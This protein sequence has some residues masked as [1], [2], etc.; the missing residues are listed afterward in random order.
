MKRLL[1]TIVALAVAVVA[2]AQTPIKPIPIGVHVSEDTTI[3]PDYARSLLYDRL[4]QIVTANGLGT[5]NNSPFF[6]T[7]S[8]NLT[9]KDII[10]GAPM[11][12]V[13]NVDISFYVADV[14][15]HRL[16]ETCTL[17]ARGVGENENRAFIA[18]FRNIKSSSPELKR[19]IATAS[20]E[21]VAYY[22][23]Q[24]DNYIKQ[25]DALAKMG[26]FEK[27]LYLLSMVPDACE[28]YGRVNDAAIAVYQKMIDGNSLKMLQKAK[29]VWAAGHDYAAAEEAGLYLAEV[30]PYSS[31]FA[32]AEALVAEIKEFV[33]SER[34]Y[35]R[36]QAEEEIA[37]L[38]KIA[39]NEQD[40]ERNRVNA[41]R[42]V[43][44][45]YG[46]NQP[47]QTYD[48]WWWGK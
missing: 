2:T 5:D 27:A 15:T 26:E 41:W 1:F 18:A 42:E 34:Q 10:A 39:E 44:V 9:D 8:I 45:A 11:R 23:S 38:R 4:N 35:D 47:K 33:I 17:S 20:T 21:I 30:S 19:L 14:Q 37:W 43:G 6:L 12:I 16:Y 36:K 3:V 22:D 7:C 48:M 46:N 29:S 25:A 24:I 31:C 40:I 13:Q 28:G 32:Q